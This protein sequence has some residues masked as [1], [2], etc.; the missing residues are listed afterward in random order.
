[1]VEGTCQL[2]AQGNLVGN[3][4]GR[5]IAGLLLHDL[6]RPRIKVRKTFFQEVALPT[7]FQERGVV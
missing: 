2:P 1:M 3:F 5:L 7:E 6:S 4:F